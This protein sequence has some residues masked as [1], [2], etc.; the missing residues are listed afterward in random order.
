MDE[1]ESAVKSP[2]PPKNSGYDGINFKFFQ[3]HWEML[4]QELFETVLSYGRERASKGNKS[5]LYNN[6]P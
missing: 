4:K 3:P 6:S 5:Y 1:L 2:D